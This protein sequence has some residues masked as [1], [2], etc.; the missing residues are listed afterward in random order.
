MKT[1]VIAGLGNPEPCHLMTRHNVGF[2]VADVLSQHFSISFS[3]VAFHK[4][5]VANHRLADINLSLVKPMTYMN[6]SGEAVASFLSYYK[7]TPSNLLVVHD[8]LDQDFGAIKFVKKGGAGGHNGIRS[9]VELLGADTFCRLK[10]G[11]GRSKS[12]VP[13]ANWVLMPFASE[14][15]KRLSNVIE[16]ACRGVLC[17][18]ECG[19]DAAM[20][21][22][23]GK[24]ITE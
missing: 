7:L 21:D 4:A 10:I 6:R 14:E 2:M 20:N 8:D 12:Q 22:F 11:I 18:M 24:L 19:I 1:F 17:F 23:N 5:L 15:Q 13:V 16:T 9:I 3:H